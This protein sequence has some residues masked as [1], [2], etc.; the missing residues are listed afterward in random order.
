MCDLCPQ[1]GV[2]LCPQRIFRAKID[3]IDPKIFMC[4]P[5]SDCLPHL[6]FIIAENEEQ[7]LEKYLD[8]ISVYKSLFKWIFEGALFE[9]FFEDDQYIGTKEWSENKKILQRGEDFLNYIDATIRERVKEYYNVNDD[10]WLNN[11]M[12][13]LYSQNYSYLSEDMSKFIIKRHLKDNA[14]AEELD[15]PVK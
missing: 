9:Y 2:K 12:R 11:F 4:Y 3:M 14:I 1:I 6:K 13:F 15:I 7:A 8:V 5:L 10:K